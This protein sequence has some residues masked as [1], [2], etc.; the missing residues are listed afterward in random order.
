MSLTQIFGESPL[1]KKMT[2]DKPVESRLDTTD[3]KL[4][5]KPLSR[6]EG[7]L[8][9]AGKATYTAEHQFDDLCHG[10]MVGATI[11]KG[12]VKKVHKDTALQVAG[13]IGVFHDPL[14]LRN[15]QQ[16]GVKM[17]PVQGASE[18]FYHGQ[19]IALVVAETLEAAQEGAKALKI[20]YEN[21]EK[22]G[23]FDFNKQKKHTQ[24]IDWVTDKSDDIGKP[25]KTLKQAEVK[26]D[27][28]YTTPSQSNMPMEPHSSLA[29][30][31]EGKL[32]LHTSNQ[33][34]A[35]S[36]VQLAKALDMP[37]DDVRLLS[38][39]VGGGFGSK[40]G[41][42]PE[43]VMAAIAA[44]DL[45]RPVLVNMTRP[46][47][48]ETTVRRTNT[49]QRVALG[50]DKD[51][52]IHTII[53]NSIVTNLPSETFFEPVAVSTHF[54]YGGDNRQIKYEM[55]RMNFTLTGSMR[56][57][58][59][60]VGQL[61]LECAMDELAHAL[62]LC[63][64]ELRKRNEPSEDPSKKI[65]YSTRKLLACMEQ[66]AKAFGWDKRPQT[67]ASR[68]DG[69]WLIGYGMA[70]AARSNELKPSQA[71]V[72]LLPSDKPLGVMA[73][74]ETDMT[75]IG[76]GSYT[77]FAQ[78]V[79][80]M[81]GLPID[82]VEVKLGDTD[83]PPA[84]GSG[85]SWGA[86]SA[87]SSIY[88]ACEALREK[89]AQSVGLHA[90]SIGFKQGNLYRQFEHDPSLAEKIGEK[91]NHTLTDT[92]DKLAEK[93]GLSAEVSVD[94]HDNVLDW[95]QVDTQLPLSSFLQQYAPHGLVANGEIEPGKTKKEYRHA[96]YGAQFAEVVVHR[97]TGEIRVRRMQGTFAAGRILNEK[98][99]RSQ[100]FGGMVFG[101]G[102]A[103]MEQIH[104]D[105]RDGRLCNHDLAEYQVCVNA[106]V[107][108]LEVIML[109]ETDPYANPLH[110]KGIGE[111][112]LSGAGAAIANAIFNATGV[113]VR[114]YPI[115][116]DKLLYQLPLL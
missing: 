51:G 103:L 77:I 19:P 79:A 112:A 31:F 86:S 41:I 85:G 108:D 11:G 53:H 72:S 32:T 3:S 58:G 68:R 83:L 52:K 92:L 98:T 78:V 113:R 27:V 36:K 25:E 101:I 107:P 95:E 84:A 81:L 66:G 114:D 93:T 80:D 82:H 73:R 87:G 106:D 110:S 56:A 109:P 88:L 34:L 14:F 96:G 13:V 24:F 116:L 69:D 5:G 111:L 64:I 23:H 37:E 39:Y 15:P 46:Q 105:K 76:T 49:E 97:V 62:K 29:R 35:S 115:T 57:P 100:C 1:E 42:S 94:S 4:V 90:D 22:H 71:R 99:A 45:K 47:V 9:V 75:D 17:A 2:M 20:D 38:P 18:V 21:D 74:I 16:G 12:K 10:V 89:I 104:H 33:M 91:I 65:P 50:A 48:M 40:L 63:P 54:L 70:C 67:P 59:E 102:A 44:K 61:A 28:I 8:K 30:W 6:I 60:A 7:H 26:V 43:S 55:A